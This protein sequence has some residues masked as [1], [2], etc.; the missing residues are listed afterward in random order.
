MALKASFSNLKRGDNFIKNLKMLNKVMVLVKNRDLVLM[1][2][3][4]K[5]HEDRSNTSEDI[6]KV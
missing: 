4:V 1:N 5:F 2:K 6:A 3:C